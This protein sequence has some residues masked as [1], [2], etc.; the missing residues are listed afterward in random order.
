LYFI[1]LY[2]CFSNSK[3]S[4]IRTILMKNSSRWYLK[5]A[6][7]GKWR[8]LYWY[9]FTDVSEKCTASIFGMKGYF[10]VTWVNLY[11][12]ARRQFQ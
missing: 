7:S 2:L 8:H 5:I 10:V 9:R 1:F 12:N 11:H 6:F 3:Y 4:F